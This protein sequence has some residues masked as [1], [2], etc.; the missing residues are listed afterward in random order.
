MVADCPL[1]TVLRS[2]TIYHVQYSFCFRNIH[3]CLFKLCCSYCTFREYWN[4]FQQLTH[5]ILHL[6]LFRKTRE[7]IRFLNGVFVI[8]HFIH[9]LSF[10][11]Y[12]FY[13]FISFNVYHFISF[14]VY[15]F[16]SFNVYYFISFNVYYYTSFVVRIT[17]LQLYYIITK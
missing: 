17:S 10:F 3:T 9:I 6:Y 14:N 4:S 15:Y 13:H 8:I 1:L 16:I 12:L 2:S 11:I 5:F 7:E